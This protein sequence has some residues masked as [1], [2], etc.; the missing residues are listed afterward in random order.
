[1]L[2]FKDSDFVP[3]TGLDLQHPPFTTDV[4]LTDGGVYDNLGLETVW[5]RYRTVLV[6]DGGG[7]LEAEGEPESDWLRHTYRVLSIIDGQVRSLRKRQVIGSFVAGERNG[8]YWGTYSDISKYGA[9]D[10]LPAPI[11]K[12]LALAKTPTRLEKMDRTLQERLIN[13]GFAICDA[14]MRKHVYSSLPA[15]DDFPY[16]TSGVG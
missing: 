14:A 5:K 16:P 4:V 10:T 15:P 11:E 6:S 3:G 9:P 1:V 8:T 12:T 7:Q 2:E 13:W